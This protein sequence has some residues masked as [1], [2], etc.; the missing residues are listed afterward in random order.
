MKHQQDEGVSP[1]ACRR[2]QER[3]ARR[4]R[5]AIASV[6]ARMILTKDQVQKLID[7]ADPRIRTTVM[8]TA[9]M[10]LRQNEVGLVDWGHVRQWRGQRSILV[11]HFKRKPPEHRAIP[12]ELWT[13]IGKLSPKARRQAFAASR[14]RLARLFRQST[15]AAALGHVSIHDMRRRWLTRRRNG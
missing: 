5:K 15:L 9:G 8:A 14:S 3:P 7:A 13:E 4:R 12:A 2:C 11:P 1:S 10:G 6:P